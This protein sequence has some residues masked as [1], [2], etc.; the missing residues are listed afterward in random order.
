MV[1]YDA[2]DNNRTEDIVKVSII[3]KPLLDDMDA[4]LDIVRLYR[5]G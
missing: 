3:E 5:L 2:N 1:W 4:R